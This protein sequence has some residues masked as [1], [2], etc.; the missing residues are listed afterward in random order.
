[1]PYIKEGERPPLDKIVEEMGKWITTP[2]HLAYLL[3]AFFKRFVGHG[4]FHFC[5]WIGAM[6]LTI[7]EIYRR[8][9]AK[10]E[11]TKIRE[12]GDVA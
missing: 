10:H 1:M 11:D 4:F 3:F 12:N 9:I 8:L 7:L 6:V 2:G 5:L